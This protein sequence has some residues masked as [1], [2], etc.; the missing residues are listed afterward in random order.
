MLYIIMNSLFPKNNFITIQFCIENT[1]TQFV[2]CYYKN[3][4][5]VGH[6][7]VQ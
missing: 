1:Y 7:Y 2:Y 4:I 3:T 5:L 6:L